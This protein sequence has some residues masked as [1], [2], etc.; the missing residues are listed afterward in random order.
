MVENVKKLPSQFEFRPFSEGKGLDQGK[1][2]ICE[3]R[4]VHDISTHVAELSRL[5]RRNSPARARKAAIRTQLTLT[6]V[7]VTGR[8][9]IL[10]RAV[11]CIRSEE[12]RVGKECR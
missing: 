10:G 1:I 11:V 8:I 12:R 2:Q 7:G 3:A 5:W 9:C 6:R 4:P